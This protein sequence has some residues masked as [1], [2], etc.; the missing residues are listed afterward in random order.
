MLKFSFLPKDICL[1]LMV[2]LHFCLIYILGFLCPVHTPDG[3]PCGLL[4]HMAASCQ[5]IDNRNS[6][7]W[8]DIHT[9]VIITTGLGL[10]LILEF[11]SNV[12]IVFLQISV[13]LSR[14]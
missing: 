2:M 7:R 12:Q 14:A 5:V 1:G 6:D 8:R 3:S 4:N 13:R 9:L 10:M 11:L